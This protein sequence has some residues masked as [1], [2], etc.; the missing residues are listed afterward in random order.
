[1]R[2]IT[3]T[4]IPEELYQA[5]VQSAGTNGRNMNHEILVC[6]HTALEAAKHKPA[7]PSSA[8]FRSKSLNAILPEKYLHA[9]IAE[10]SGK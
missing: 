2:C 1:M 7:M 10:A 4:S 3:I 8:Q 9:A 6:L 5:L